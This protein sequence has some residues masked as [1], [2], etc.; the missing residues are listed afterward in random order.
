MKILRL[1]IAITSVLQGLLCNAASTDTISIRSEPMAKTYKAAIVLPD[2]YTKNNNNYP[3]LY[4]LHGGY[5]HFDDWLRKTPDNMLVKNL[6]DQYNIII[7]MPEGEVFSYYWDSP[8]DA[9]SQFESYITQD[10]VMAIDAKY[11]T[12]RSNKGR[13]ITGLS[14]GGYG[15]LYLAARHPDIYGAAGSMSGAMNPDMEGW[16]TDATRAA[17]IKKEF[18]KKLGPMEQNAA[19]FAAKSVLNMADTLKANGTKIIFDCGVDDFLIEPNRELHKRLMANK[20]PHDY[21]ERPGTHA[22]EYWQNSLPYHLLFFSKVLKANGV[23]V[24]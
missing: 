21:S 13:A 15:A 23:A 10:V 5:G 3:V 24:L 7:V 4:L 14:M 11:R 16:K 1:L 6:A 12:V 22:W 20:T 18:E 2:S 8:V 17:G 19:L 9:A